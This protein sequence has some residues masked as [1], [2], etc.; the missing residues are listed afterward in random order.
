VQR[1]RGV[2]NKFNVR[3]GIVGGCACM[4][5]VYHTKKERKKGEE[6]EE[7]E[8]KQTNEPVRHRAHQSSREGR[9]VWRCQHI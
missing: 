7:K 9:N 8:Q 3:L 5:H 6:E 4:P 1:E 2:H